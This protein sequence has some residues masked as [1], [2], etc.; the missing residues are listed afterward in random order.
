VAV[1]FAQELKDLRA[2]LEPERQLTDLDS[3]P[4]KIG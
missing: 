1:D 3:L 4:T 2:T